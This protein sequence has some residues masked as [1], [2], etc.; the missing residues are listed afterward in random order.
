MIHLN[1]LKIVLYVLAALGVIWILR[2]L[3]P[4]KQ[5]FIPAFILGLMVQLKAELLSLS[6]RW[7]SAALRAGL[8]I[9]G[10]AMNLRK[11][12]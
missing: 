10:E 6:A 8:T 12:G 9:G 3:L 11:L 5:E 7:S 2:R 1:V 4:R